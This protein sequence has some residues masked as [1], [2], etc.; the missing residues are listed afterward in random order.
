MITLDADTRLPRGAARRLVG[1]IAHPL[2]RPRLDPRTGRVVEGYAV[3]QPRVTPSL[4]A[5][6]GGSL[7]QRVFSG[8]GGID[9]YAFA[10]SDVYQDLL[11]EGSYTGKGIYDVDAFEAALAGRVPDSALLSHDLLEGIFARAG[12]VSDVELVEDF[13]A[14]YDVAAAR[15]HRWARG[16][17]QLL[18][19]VLGRGSDR[20]GDR[21]RTA[22]PLIGR[23]KLLDNL[24]RTLV[25]PAAY[26]LLLTGWTL[27]I[28]PAAMASGFVLATI[29]IPTL[30]PIFAGLIPQ[31]RGV[32]LRSHTRAL[33]GD[34]A[35][36]LFHV[37]LVTALLAHQAWLMTDAIV[38]TLFRLFVR[39]RRMLEWLTAAQAQFSLPLDAGGF[40][41]RMA[42]GVAL[43]VLAAIL[44]G[45]AGHGSWP[46]AAP[47][48]T[49]W[50]LSPIIAEW[51]SRRPA[52]AS[53][54]RVTPA[55]ARALRSIARR[56]WRFFE[57]FVG[58]GDHM[59]PPD[60][61]QQEPDP[62]LAHRTSPTNIGLYLLSTATAHDFGWIGVLDTVARIEATL[63]TVEGLEHCR[64]HLY[65]WYD[66][67]DL[68]PLE[69]R[70][71]SSV[72]S[73]NLAG[74]LI[75]LGN[76]CRDLIDVSVVNPS[77]IAGIDDAVQLIHAS[78]RA[79]TH[80]PRTP[81]VT[82]AQLDDALTAFTQKLG[83]AP[84]TPAEV[85]DRL[86]ELMLE[87]DIVTDIAGTL[88]A[89]HEDQGHAEVLVWARALR[90]CVANH[91]RDFEELMPWGRLVDIAEGPDAVAGDQALVD[92]FTSI[93]TLAEL[94][95]RC[96][97]AL[98]G[99][100]SRRD[101]GTDADR[102]AAPATGTVS[103]HD[104]LVD[105]LARS[106]R[107]ARSLE[108]RLTALHERVGRYVKAME[109]AFLFDPKRQL[110][111]I[112]YQVAEGRLDPSCYDLLA[113]EACLA[114]FVA[115]AKGDVPAV[116]WFRL[117]RALTPVRG[118]AV[119]VSW[120]GSLFEYL[121]PG[122]V[123]Q[124]PPGS[125]LAQT[126]RLVVGRQ[127]QY[128]AERR[129]TL[130]R[131]RIRL[132]RARPGAHVSVFELRRARTRTQARPQRRH[133]DRTLRDSIGGDG[134][135]ASR[136]AEPRAPPRGRRL[137]AIRLLR[138]ARLH[139]DAP[140]TGNLGRDRPRVHGT[141][142]GHDHRRDRQRASRRRDACPISCRADR[143]GNGAPA[144][145]AASPGRRDRPA[146]RRGGPG[147]T[148]TVRVPAADVA[149]IPYP[150]RPDSPH[151]HAVQWPVRRRAHGGGLRIQPLAKRRCDTLA[152][153]RHM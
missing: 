13:P 22:I 100:T 81:T 91:E 82:R 9:P 85:G 118:G 7:F 71:V 41:R 74:H 144:A 77:W 68:R 3:L 4:P 127:I 1:K 141:S 75:A 106:A 152:R 109:F 21:H 110:L 101:A 10:V 78:L 40:F 62:V 142:P 87:A 32:S 27:G 122:L 52:I 45:L 12:L 95:N 153:G 60:N 133:R 30:A 50:L 90:E 145:G 26:L 70:Y 99:L 66:T 97:A 126:D 67:R 140:A 113:S 28:V 46:I 96:D 114:S 89:E 18:P 73:G 20:S 143:A 84:T 14:R 35:A 102:A 83:S 107:A 86:R 112:G 6:G 51:A 42:G 119:L 11:D 48:V 108:R 98:G 16:D 47:F 39:R 150:A 131:F 76:A 69:P 136:R 80:D 129:R 105:A 25:A 149:S 33:L 137:R 92:L 128:G 125:L 54:D 147:R 115:I 132:Q 111:S 55:S 38:R 19:W 29:A 64:G 23:W 134:E 117:G 15:Q 88:A 24:R 58:E 123:M 121:M 104:A 36:G 93:P 148:H 65:N 61:F 37:L 138:S 44:I 63:D 2:N 56:T 49:L 116:H 34:V 94:S 103:R 120:S 72:D 17:W 43:A 57:S 8:P 146:A 31:R 139:P 130:G 151:P 53:D 5:L 79:L 124:A 135:P 59:L